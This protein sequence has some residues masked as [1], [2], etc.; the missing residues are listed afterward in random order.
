M[1]TLTY[2]LTFF[3]LSQSAYIDLDISLFDVD[4]IESSVQCCVPSDHDNGSDNDE[5]HQCSPF[6]GDDCC[7]SAMSITYQE[8]IKDIVEEEETFYF[9]QQNNYTYSYRILLY[10]PPQYNS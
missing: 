5:S 9:S 7:T 2:I 1:K 4:C 3:V 6:C 8:R 10:Q